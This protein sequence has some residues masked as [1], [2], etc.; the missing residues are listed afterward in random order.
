[1]YYLKL[2]NVIK[3]GASTDLLGRDSPAVT[4]VADLFFFFFKDFIIA[5]PSLAPTPQKR[6][7]SLFFPRKGCKL[8]LGQNS[9][10]SSLF[11]WF[12]DRGIIKV[13]GG[14]FVIGGSGFGL[15]LYFPVGDCV[16]PCGRQSSITQRT[17]GK[18]GVLK[19]SL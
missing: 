1:M 15:L 3:A 16:L 8:R 13:Y 19:S 12:L 10:W 9:F 5:F 4:E 6:L 14:C 18:I 7:L 17:A 2:A 11:R